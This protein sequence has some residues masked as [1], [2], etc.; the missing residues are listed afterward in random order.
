MRFW[1]LVLFFFVFSTSS[2]AEDNILKWA[3]PTTNVDGSVLKETDITRYD[4]RYGS[5]PVASKYDEVVSTKEKTYTHKVTE[6]GKYCYQ[7]RAVTT[8]ASD[9][10]SEKCKVVSLKPSKPTLSSLQ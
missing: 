2:N 3:A 6:N 5:N 8:V 7:V 10:S 9:W 4:V 1:I